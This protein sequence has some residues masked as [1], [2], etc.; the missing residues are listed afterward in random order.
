MTIDE[1]QLIYHL[2][3]ANGHI[4]GLP[5]PTKPRGHSDCGPAWGALRAGMITIRRFGCARDGRRQRCLR[6][7]RREL[8]QRALE[9]LEAR[10]ER[11]LVVVDQPAQRRRDGGM[12]FVGKIGA[13][14]GPNYG[15]DGRTKEW[16][17]VTAAQVL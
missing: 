14:H 7:G 12:F 3:R 2:N 1:E 11:E 15:A 4:R 8:R 10:R 9:R 5:I 16:A 13:R 6:L 17:D